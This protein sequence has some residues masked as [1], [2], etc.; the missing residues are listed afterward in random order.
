MAATQTYLIIK[1]LLHQIQLLRPGGLETSSF[2]LNLL[3]IKSKVKLLV[4]PGE[5]QLYALKQYITLRFYPAFALVPD[6]FF[7]TAADK[8]P[9]TDTTDTYNCIELSSHFT[10]DLHSLLQFLLHLEKH[11]L[12]L[13]LFPSRATAI[14]HC[15]EQKHSTILLSLVLSSIVQVCCQLLQNKSAFPLFWE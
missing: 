11:D 8:P 10:R 2:H 15:G 1:P 4:T 12:F 6:I 9:I 14:C 7:N 5:A 3:F 13:S